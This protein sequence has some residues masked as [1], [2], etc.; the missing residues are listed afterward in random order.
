MTTCTLLVKDGRYPPAERH[1]ATLPRTA[2]LVPSAAHTVAGWCPLGLIPSW[3]PQSTP[4]AY[5]SFFSILPSAALMMRAHSRLPA[6]HP[7][8]PRTG[9]CDAPH[10]KA[11]CI[12]STSASHCLCSGGIACFSCSA[13]SNGG[14]TARAGKVNSW[15]SNWSH[16]KQGTGARL[17]G[18]GRHCAEVA[19][20]QA[21]R[22]AS[23]PAH[24]RA[25]TR[26]KPSPAGHAEVALACPPVRPPSSR[27]CQP[28]QSMWSPTVAPQNMAPAA[29]LLAL[30][31]RASRKVSCG[32][33]RSKAGTALKAHWGVQR[34]GCKESQRQHSWYISLPQ[35]GPTCLRPR[36]KLQPELACTSRNISLRC[37]SDHCLPHSSSTNGLP[38]TSALAWMWACSHCPNLWG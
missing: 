34:I 36:A 22:A 10:L 7:H 14:A 17:P 31:A 38:T 18:K 30:A 3:S 35:H 20:R 4:M 29:G 12:A 1:A 15:I 32:A 2:C 26:I 11:A 28:S 13:A 8:P 23:S 16:A 9:I 25:S 19:A 37:C 21:Y 5:S 27:T 6:C 33:K 24:R